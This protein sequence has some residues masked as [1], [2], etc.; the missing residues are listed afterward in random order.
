MI[1]SGVIVYVSSRLARQTVDALLDAA[2]AGYRARII[3]AVLK[4]NGVIEVERVRIRRAGNRYFADLTVGLARNVT[5][6]RSGQVVAEI[7]DAAHAILP[8]CDVVVH[9]IPRETAHENIFDRVRA[10]ASRNNFSAWP[11]A[12]LRKSSAIA[13][14]FG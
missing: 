9:S 4:I 14:K 5:F 1:V 6:Q 11:N 2:P 8:E 12:S 3:D 10:V 13:S 7:T